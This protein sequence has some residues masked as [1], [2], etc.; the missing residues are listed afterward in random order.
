MCLMSLAV[1][2]WLSVSGRAGAVS[3]NFTTIGGD[4]LTG[5]QLAAFATAVAAWSAALTDP[6]QVQIGFRDLRAVNSPMIFEATSSNSE[7]K[8]YNAFQAG[9]TADATSGTDTAAVAHLP[10]SVPSSQVLLTTAQARAAGLAAAATADGSIEFTSHAGISHA[11]T[12]AAL[13]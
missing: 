4:T 3:F 5:A 13:T 10:V 12:R 2:G 7:V 11:T 6:V 1:G 8:A 9:L